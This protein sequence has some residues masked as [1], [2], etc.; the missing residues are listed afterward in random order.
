MKIVR[1][2]VDSVE[3]IPDTLGMQVSRASRAVAPCRRLRRR[4]L[5]PR[6]CVQEC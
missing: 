1:S 4:A 6:I 2:L 5:R 3:A